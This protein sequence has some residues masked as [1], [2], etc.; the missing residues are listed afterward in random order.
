[1][2]CRYFS[3][4][5]RETNRANSSTLHGGF[6]RFTEASTWPTRRPACSAREFWSTRHTRSTPPSA[7]SEK[8]FFADRHFTTTDGFAHSAS[9][10]S[11][12]PH[13]DRSRVRPSVTTA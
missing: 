2:N 13:G 3:L 7:R 4:K 1:M 5:S 11:T 8:P 12:T 9:S 6:A 10:A